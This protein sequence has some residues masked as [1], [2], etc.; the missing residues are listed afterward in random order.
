MK[1]IALHAQV[2]EGLGKGSSRKLRS[3]GFVPAVFYGYEAEPITIKVN[4]AELVKALVKE[5]GE[6]VFVKLVI[7]SGK[8]GGKVEKLSVIKDMQVDTASRK[9]VHVDF[10][11]I[12]ADRILSV[13]V[14]LILSGD[15]VGLE[16]GGELQQLKR[17]LKVSGLPADLPETLEIDVSGLDIGDSVKVKDIVVQGEAQILDLEDVAVASVVPTRASLIMTEETGEKEEATA[18]AATSVSEDEQ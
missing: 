13:D 4:T 5:R 3:G 16:R 7:D 10:Y 14:P 1:T 12:R 6:T 18:E 17:A 2:R 15:P 8:G 11:A 9:P